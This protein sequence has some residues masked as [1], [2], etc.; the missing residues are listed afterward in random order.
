[1]NSVLS[2]QKRPCHA[3][4][5]RQDSHA[6]LAPSAAPTFATKL[7]I[8]QLPAFDAA[9]PGIDLRTVATEALCGF[10]HD[11]VDIAV[12]LTRPPI[13]RL[14]EARRLFRQDLVPVAS[15]HLVAPTLWRC[16]PCICVRDDLAAGGLV[17]M[18]P[19]DFDAGRNYYLVRKGT[20]A[21]SQTLAVVWE[22][23]LANWSC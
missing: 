11:Q 3:V 13:S 10:D 16:R 20:A 1:M 2:R 5:T 18:C 6:R 23:C 12:G 19:A 9:L 14:G 8:A 15:P 4:K 21:P 17:E 7:L 22:G